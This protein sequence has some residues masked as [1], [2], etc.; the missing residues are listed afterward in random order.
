MK[1]SQLRLVFI[2]LLPVILLPI[3]VISQD[4]V[5]TSKGTLEIRESESEP[6][7]AKSLYLNNKKIFPEFTS[8]ADFAMIEKSFPTKNPTLIL[9]NVG[10]GALV[11]GQKFMLLDVSGKKPFLSKKFGNCGAIQ[12]TIYKNGVLTIYF[13]QGGEP[14]PGTYYVGKR[15][16]W[17]YLNRK[18]TKMK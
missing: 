8:A 9:I 18:L 4:S 1:N 12:K 11:C 15:E 7:T 13:P 14:D 10:D 17:Q 5:K 3:S 2:L 6:E 16:I